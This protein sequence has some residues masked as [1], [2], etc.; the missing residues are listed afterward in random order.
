MLC[1]PFSRKSISL[2]VYIPRGNS[3]RGGEKREKETKRW[4]LELLPIRNSARIL[5]SALLFSSN[6]SGELEPLSLLYRSTNSKRYPW[7][8][9]FKRFQ[10]QT[11]LSLSLSLSR[12]GIVMRC[13][14]TPPFAFAFCIYSQSVGERLFFVGGKNAQLTCRCCCCN[15]MDPSGKGGGL[16]LIFVRACEPANNSLEFENVAEID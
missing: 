5:Y 13:L 12:Y 16:D 8:F 9:H 11:S 1:Y 3:G 7:Y 15:D 4:F 6:R 14:K 10:A 2:K